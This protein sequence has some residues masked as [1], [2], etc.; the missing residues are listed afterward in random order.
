[1]RG[2]VTGL[3]SHTTRPSEPYSNRPTALVSTTTRKGPVLVTVE[4]T[5]PGTGSRDIFST[6]FVRRLAIFL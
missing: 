2:P 5:W 1:M 4:I 6:A 3:I